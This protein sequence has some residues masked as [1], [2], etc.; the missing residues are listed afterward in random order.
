M[1]YIRSPELIHL[2]TASMC[3]LTNIFPLPTPP[4][5]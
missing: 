5:P 3:P 2:P 1:L 4:R